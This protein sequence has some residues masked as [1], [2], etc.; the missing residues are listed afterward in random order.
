MKYGLKYGIS[1]TPKSSTV[2]AYSDDV[3]D[4]IRKSDIY[5]NSAYAKMKIKNAIRSYAFNL[6][7]TDDKNIFKDANKIKIIR[8]LRK[9]L[10]ILKPDKGNG[11]VLLN[12][13]DYTNSMESLFRDKTKF[14]QLDSDPTISQLSS[15]QS[16][17]RKLKNNNG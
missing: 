9:T 16:S 4:Q 1:F 10:V 5:Y 7:D 11:I 15:L 8:H 13:E 17:L 6:I 2:F 14:K 3:W 12:K